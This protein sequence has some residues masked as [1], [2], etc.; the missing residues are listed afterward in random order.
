MYEYALKVCQPYLLPPW[1]N[2]LNI[3]INDHEIVKVHTDEAKC[4]YI[5]V[6]DSSLASS[7]KLKS[8]PIIA[9]YKTTDWEQNAMTSILVDFIITIVRIWRRQYNWNIIGILKKMNRSLYNNKLVDQLRED[10]R[11]EYLE[12]LMVITDNKTTFQSENRH[13]FLFI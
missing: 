9:Q 3:F 7:L 6:C 8:M 11:K 13:K 10:E 5:N 12:K 4:S 2:S 1:N